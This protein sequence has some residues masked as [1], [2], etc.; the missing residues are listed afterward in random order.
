M[1]VGVGARVAVGMAVGVRVAVGMGVGVRVAMGVGV[2]VG[3]GVG[4]RVAVGDKRGGGL[5]W[6]K[7]G[8][9]APL[10]RSLMSALALRHPVAK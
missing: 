6:Q 8:Q 9:L 5:P 7:L 3:V 2:G 4:A 10:W 1:G